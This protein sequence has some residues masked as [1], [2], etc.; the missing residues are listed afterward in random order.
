MK[1]KFY[2]IVIIAIIII[3]IYFVIKNPSAQ[4][5]IENNATTENIQNNAKDVDSESMSDSEQTPSPEMIPKTIINYTDDGFNPS[6][7]EIK[8]GET[9]QFVNQSSGGMWVASGPHPAHTAYPEFDAK[10]NITSGE[11][12][13]FTFTKIGEWKYHNHTKAGMYG[14]IIVK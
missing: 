7:V 12:Y 10:K 6:L 14:A 8:V 5:Q 4:P 3:G 9:V 11:T 2:I 1:S 13:E